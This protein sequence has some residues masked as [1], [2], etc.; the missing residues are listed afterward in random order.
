MGPLVRCTGV[1][2]VTTLVLLFSVGEFFNYDCSCRDSFVEVGD[3]GS[4]TLNTFGYISIFRF[5]RSTFA[6][7]VLRSTL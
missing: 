3:R 1:L 4:A 5:G 6:V 7:G 2:K